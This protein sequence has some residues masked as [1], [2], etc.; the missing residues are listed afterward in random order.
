MSH[1]EHG[2]TLIELLVVVAIMAILA[3]ILFPVFAS[4]QAKARSS[5]CLSNIKQIGLGIMMYTEDYDGTF[6]LRQ[7]YCSVPTPPGLGYLSRRWGWY[8]I[9][10]PYVKNADVFNCPDGIQGYKSYP[11]QGHYG[12]NVHLTGIGAPWTS[13]PAPRHS[14]IPAPADLLMAFDSGRFVAEYYTVTNP[15]GEALYMPGTCCGRDPTGSNAGRPLT[16]FWRYD[17]QAGRHNAGNNI[18]F[19]DGHAKWIGGASL[20][21]HPEYWDPALQ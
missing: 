18:V 16:G 14:D 13:S 19:A 11:Y 17:Y 1:P 6:P 3:A 7:Y 15:Y 21:D 12:M 10:Y 8:N 4:A 5:A 9:V 2:F 20:L